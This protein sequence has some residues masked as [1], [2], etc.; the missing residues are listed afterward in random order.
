MRLRKSIKKL[1]NHK[2]GIKPYDIS[3]YDKAFMNYPEKSR[4]LKHRYNLT[5]GIRIGL[6]DDYP[7][8]LSNNNPSFSIAEKIGIA[9]QLEKW[10]KTGIVLGPYDLNYAKDNNITLHM[11]FGVPKPDG[12]TR[13]ILNLSDKT[14][15]NYSIN[16]L[17]DPNLCT[18]EYAQ[19]KQVVE[20]VRALGKNAW[21]WAKDLKDG[22]Y[23][24]SVN[25]KDIHKLGFIF[26]GKIYIFQRLPMGLSSSPNIFTEFMHFPIWAIKQDRP[27]LYYKKV[28]E[29]LINLNNFMKDADV[30]KRGSTAILATL[31]Y[32]LDDILGG[33][34]D[35]DKAWEQFSHSEKVLKL[36][37]LQT[38]GAKAKPPAQIQQ[39]LGKIYN[40]K[41]QW[42]TLP[43]EKIKKYISELK[44]ATTKQSITQQKLLSHIGRIRHMA[45]IY[46]PLAAFARN[47]EVWAYSVKQLSHHI[48]MT[49]PLKNDLMLAIW[50]IKRA[51]QYGIS[52]D[53][54]LKP[55]DIPDIVCFTDASLKIGLGGYSNHGHWFKNDWNNIELYHSNNRDIVW[56]ELVAIFALIHSLK[57][58]LIKKVVHMYT[59]NEA[60]K[61][62]LIKMRA[63]L[64]RPDLQI[65]INEICKLCIRYEIILWVEHIPGKENIIPDALSRNKS[66]PT[67]LLNNCTNRISA[68]N[69]IQFAADLCRNIVINKKHLC[70]D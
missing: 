65:I 56:K 29:A 19:T 5:N 22:Y 34:H 23:N 21:L 43:P 59:D 11:L 32:Y 62:M 17:I 67:K 18:V 42:I 28:D 25:K 41:K 37:S 39:W 12:S 45:S 16:N 54:F 38:K 68:T 40:T 60:C 57:D 1:S 9:Q 4:Y 26:E 30:E 47:L 27:D 33:H 3:H 55:M 2:F 61:Y 70:F 63:K 7:T 49:R 58:S 14:F 48:R 51:A 64:T 13:P 8:R 66:I 31:F 44:S 53:Q 15:F 52:F 20:T 10:L 6:T 24:V 69:S 35:K 46:R 50:G 36:L